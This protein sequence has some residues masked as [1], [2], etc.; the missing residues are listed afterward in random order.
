[1]SSVPVYVCSNMGPYLVNISSEN[2]LEHLKEEIFR[3]EKIPKYL[4][5]ISYRGH[6]FHSDSQILP[7]SSVQMII[8]GK[9]GMKEDDIS[10]GK[11]SLLSSNVFCISQSHVRA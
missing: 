2:P 5:H 8:K 6:V 3:I 10:E 4:Q 1:L 11:L 9:G 7:Y